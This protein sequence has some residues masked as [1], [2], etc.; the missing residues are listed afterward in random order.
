M[1]IFSCEA[2]WDA[3]FE[4]LLDFLG[5]LDGVIMSNF[6]NISSYSCAILVSFFLILWVKPP[7]QKRLSHCNQTSKIH[8]FGLKWI[9]LSVSFYAYPHI[10]L[11]LLILSGWG[12][13]IISHPVVY[14]SKGALNIHLWGS[15]FAS[16]SF[17]P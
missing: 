10:V 12:A 17:T 7:L 9:V 14:F 13:I 11:T 5:S 16:Q 8:I 4:S 6:K 15:L 1:F 2:S 3:N